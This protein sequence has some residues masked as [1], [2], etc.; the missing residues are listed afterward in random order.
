M[1]DTVMGAEQSRL[2]GSRAEEVA[3]REYQRQHA[4]REK[5][6]RKQ[7]ATAKNS[8]REDRK[9]REYVQ[10]HEDLK[11]K[12]EQQQGELNKATKNINAAQRKLNAS[13]S[14]NSQPVTPA[15]SSRISIRSVNNRVSQGG[16]GPAASAPARLNNSFSQ[17]AL[18]MATQVSPAASAPAR[19]NNRF[20]QGGLR[21]ASPAASAPA[22]GQ[23]RPAVSA[24]SLGGSMATPVSTPAS[25]FS[26]GGSMARST[27]VNIPVNKI[28]S[29][30][31]S[32]VRMLANQSETGVARV[33]TN[34]QANYIKE[35][36]LRSARNA[37]IPEVTAR[38]VVN[39]LYR[40]KVQNGTIQIDAMPAESRGS[41]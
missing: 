21:M 3:V 5:I 6:H 25:A 27:P 8:A 32:R 10:R 41:V 17:G 28:N 39:A 13:R 14:R 11:R 34:Q 19:L 4:V 33:T 9:I 12:Y 36:G 38:Q 18:S 40:K 16:L 15:Q 20:S 31:L 37:G 30:M 1:M 24:F 7:D 22:F 29:G 2:G 35:G 23:G 26:L